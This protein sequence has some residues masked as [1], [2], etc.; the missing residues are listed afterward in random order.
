MIFA[1]FLYFLGLAA[2]LGVL[3]YAFANP[4][5]K[6]IKFII[7]ISVVLLFVLIFFGFG[8]HVRTPNINEESIECVTEFLSEIE[9]F[10]YNFETEVISGTIYINDENE[11]TIDRNDYVDYRYKKWEVK[12]GTTDNGIKYIIPLFFATHSEQFWYMY[13]P[14]GAYG[15]M[16][17]FTDNK[18]V[19]ISYSYVDENPLI[20]L[21]GI[22]APAYFYCPEINIGDVFDGIVYDTIW[23]PVESDLTFELNDDGKS[24]SVTGCSLSVGG[25]L[26]IPDSHEGLP[27]TSI[28]NYAFAECEKITQAT[29]PDSVTSIGDSAF[30]GCIH[31]TSVTIPD[32][33]TSIGYDAFEFC[34]IFS[35]NGFIIK[36][37]KGSAAEKYAKVNGI[38]FNEL[39][40]QE[41]V[42][43]E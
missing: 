22:I 3:V 29:I 16:Y 31:L 9:G 30:E 21:S 6:H 7:I 28:G 34:Y 40:G 36:G 5:K 39:T 43:P 42:Y 26:V 12:E 19:W 17:F 20:F 8:T 4:H 14:T 35:D 15:D 33:V 1:R 41:T 11:D 23:N 38:I 10:E 24:Y 18:R 13:Y 2:L 32:S 25:Q 27:V 37:S